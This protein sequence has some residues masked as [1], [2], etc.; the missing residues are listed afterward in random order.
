[1]YLFSVVFLGLSYSNWSLSWKRVN[2]PKRQEKKRSQRKILDLEMK[3]IWHVFLPAILFY[4]AF[5]N[6]LG[7]F[8]AFPP[9][10]RSA[11]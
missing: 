5:I 4:I 7:G 1:M 11:M 6:L 3:N 8:S 2:Q 10:S 9:L